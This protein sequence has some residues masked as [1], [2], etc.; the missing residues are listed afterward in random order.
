MEPKTSPVVGTQPAVSPCYI[1]NPFAHS[2]NNNNNN[3]D[4]VKRSEGPRVVRGAYNWG[5][6]SGQRINN[7]GR[8]T[9]INKGLHFTHWHPPP[10][11][12]LTRPSRARSHVPRGRGVYALACIQC[13]RCYFA[14]RKK[15]RSKQSQSTT[16]KFIMERPGQ[17]CLYRQSCCPQQRDHFVQSRATGKADLTGWKFKFSSSGNNVSATIRGYEKI[18]RTTNSL[19]LIRPLKNN[20]LDVSYY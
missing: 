2:N 7:W 13:K 5:Q 16:T 12:S 11:V 17:S 4:G 15:K 6:F 1:H 3:T 10:T 18:V 14:C 8:F 19:F 20:L 9:L